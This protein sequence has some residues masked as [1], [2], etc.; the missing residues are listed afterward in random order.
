M[1]LQLKTDLRLWHI[2]QLLILSLVS[3]SFTRLIEET[4][5]ICTAF[6]VCIVAIYERS[7]VLFKHLWTL[8]WSS[9]HLVQFCLK[10]WI[11]LSISTVKPTAWDEIT[12]I[13]RFPFSSIWLIIFLWINMLICVYIYSFLLNL[14]VSFLCLALAGGFKNIDSYP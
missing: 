9:T 6:C 5:F 11:L 10:N 2:Y 7:E 4:K 13:W 3:I 12:L 14:H 1:T 8:S